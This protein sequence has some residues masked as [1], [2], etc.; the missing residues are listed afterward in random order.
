MSDKKTAS[1]ERTFLD[2]LK[3]LIQTE[4][5]LARCEKA[6]ATKTNENVISGKFSEIKAYLEKQAR[7]YKKA[8]KKIND[9]TEKYKT[10]VEGEKARYEK[11]RNKLCAEKET[12]QVAELDSVAL[13]KKTAKKY[14]NLK[15]TR[16]Y[17]QIAYYRTEIRELENAGRKKKAAKKEKEFSEYKLELKE[18]IT[19]LE[20]EIARLTNENQMD[21]D[22][23]RKLI[24]A[25][26]IEQAA[27]RLRRTQKLD[28]CAELDS[29][30]ESLKANINSCRSKVKE[31]DKEIKKADKKFKDVLSGFKVQEE[32]EKQKASKQTLGQKMLG[33]AYIA[34]T[35]DSIDYSKDSKTKKDKI[36]VVVNHSEDIKPEVIAEEA[37]KET[38]AIEVKT[39]DD[40]EKEARESIV[41]EEAPTTNMAGRI[42]AKVEESLNFEEDDKEKKVD[43]EGQ[44]KTNKTPKNAE[45]T[46][47]D[48]VKKAKKAKNKILKSLKDF[49]IE[50]VEVEPQKNKKKKEK[51]SLSMAK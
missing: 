15:G 27:R 7:R 44:K 29:K 26:K 34:I 35:G 1:K 13:Y 18:R 17:E 30:L 2:T 33:R 49:F 50:E 23:E 3:Q 16:A 5:E 9:I 37:I 19:V 8:S 12:C 20:N 51:E 42:I 43:I 6:Y 31:K 11:S 25:E 4:E 40:I 28:F 24:R 22:S 38:T 14:G 36:K 41:V 32:A 46:F 10:F 21:N 48:V 39:A 45:L 47:D